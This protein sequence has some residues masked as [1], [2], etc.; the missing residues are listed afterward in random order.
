MIKTHTSYLSKKTSKY[1]EKMFCLF[2]F[3]SDIPFHSGEASKCSSI[4]P[5]GHKQDA[6][7]HEDDAH[8][9]KNDAYGLIYDANG[10]EYEAHGRHVCVQ[11]ELF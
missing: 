4:A 10:H 1:E 8:G 9:H 6:H 3:F 11:G 5:P 2:L 7:G